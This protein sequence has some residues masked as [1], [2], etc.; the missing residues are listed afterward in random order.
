M[1]ASNF[2]DS[3]G[4]FILYTLDTCRTSLGRLPAGRSFGAV[5]PQIITLPAVGHLEGVPRLEISGSHV[6]ASNSHALRMNGV[7]DRRSE[8]NALKL[9]ETEG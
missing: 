8:R 7:D 2:G 1:D 6:D 5:H 9:A 3:T 4:I